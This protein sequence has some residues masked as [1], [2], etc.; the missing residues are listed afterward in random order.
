MKEK[1]LRH[2]GI[3]FLFLLASCSLITSKKMSQS[4][5][6]SI[7]DAKR[8]WKRAINKTTQRWNV[9]PGLQLSFILTES[10]FRPRAKTDRTYIFGFL[11]SGR[12]SSAYGYAQA[13]D[14]TWET[15]QRKSGNRLSSRTDFAD[16]VDFIG[17]YTNETTKK[18]NIPKSDVFNQYLAYHQGHAGFKRGHYKKKPNLISVAKRTQLNA[19]KFN[20]QLKNCR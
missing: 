11:P 7:L 8:S 19:K 10:N 18:L 20:Q 6:C 15:Y 16:S 4:D 2:L 12:L 13:I 5:A 3:I 1:N 14:A 9:S 17:W